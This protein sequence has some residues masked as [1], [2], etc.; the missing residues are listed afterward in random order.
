MA[1]ADAVQASQIGAQQRAGRE[2]ETGWGPGGLR[3]AEAAS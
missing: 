3:K 1:S 2:E